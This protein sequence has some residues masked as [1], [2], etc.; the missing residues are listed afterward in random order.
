MRCF[1]IF[2]RR[3]AFETLLSCIISHQ[4]AHWRLFCS[5]NQRTEGKLTDSAVLQTIRNTNSQ[6]LPIWYCS[7]CV[8]IF[9]TFP[10][11][12]NSCS[13]CKLLRHQC[14][15]LPSP[16][17]PHLNCPE[18]K[19]GFLLL[20]ILKERVTKNLGEGYLNAEGEPLSSLF[21]FRDDYIFLYFLC[22]LPFV[23]TILILSNHFLNHLSNS[24][25]EG[26]QNLSRGTP[27]LPVCRCANTERL[28]FTS[29]VNLESPI[30]PTSMNLDWGKDPERAQVGMGENKQ[31]PHRKKDPRWP[32]A[33]NQEPSCCEATG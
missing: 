3:D 14:P 11:P 30:N 28:T 16:T 6:V 15:A 24:A 21:A 23:G 19:Q 13:V 26:S 8:Y 22:K 4:H 17:L 20:S 32:T 2:S 31:T 29:A 27:W 9:I 1:V 5:S 18:M 33:S 10:N 12:A 25:W 7:V